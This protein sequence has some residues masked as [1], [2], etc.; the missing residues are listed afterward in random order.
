ML[1][2]KRDERIDLQRRMTDGKQLHV[3]FA[4]RPV[5]RQSMSISQ[6]SPSSKPTRR[7]YCVVSL[8][9]LAPLLAVRNGGNR[10]QNRPIALHAKNGSLL[11]AVWHEFCLCVKIGDISAEC[12]ATTPPSLSRSVKEVERPYEPHAQPSSAASQPGPPEAAQAAR[13]WTTSG[14]KAF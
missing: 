13:R 12:R 9:W 5:L 14:G 1:L 2:E 3:G 10:R 7:E 11:D 4:R 6:T 8:K